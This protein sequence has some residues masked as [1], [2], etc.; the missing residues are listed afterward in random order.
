MSFIDTVGPIIAELGVCY[1]SESIASVC[2]A[3]KTFILLKTD[4]SK[5]R[6]SDDPFLAQ[7]ISSEKNKCLE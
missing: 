3:L 6:F 1:Y 5:L 7:G 2:F 4:S